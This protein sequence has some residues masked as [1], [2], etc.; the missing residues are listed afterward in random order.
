MKIYA[1]YSDDG[2]TY[3]LISIFDIID[4]YKQFCKINPNIKLEIE[5]FYKENYKGKLLHINTI[6]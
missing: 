2:K 1:N 5:D 3:K 4:K 6:N